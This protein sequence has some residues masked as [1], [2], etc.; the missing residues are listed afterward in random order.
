MHGSAG[1]LEGLVERIIHEP[2]FD[3]TANPIG[4][5]LI[6]RGITL[7]RFRQWKS[8]RSIA[9]LGEVFDA[10]EEKNTAEVL[11]LL[12]DVRF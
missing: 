1:P 3:M 9:Q 6:E 11:S 8:G 10:T 5:Y 4:R 12:D 7:D 2:D